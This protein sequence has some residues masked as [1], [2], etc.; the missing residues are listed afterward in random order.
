MINPNEHGKKQLLI[1]ALS[2]H[3]S[4]LTEESHGNLSE[5]RQCPDRDSDRAYVYSVTSTCSM[6]ILGR[7][8][9]IYDFLVPTTQT[10]RQPV[11]SSKVVTACTQISQLK[12][13]YSR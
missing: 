5:C 10:W 8:V 4:G 9:T 3:L 1:E 2:E 6:L 13:E 11:E 7:R 12:Y